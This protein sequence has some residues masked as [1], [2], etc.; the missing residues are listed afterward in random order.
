M[1]TPFN[2]GKVTSDGPY[3]LAIEEKPD[4]RIEILAGIYVLKPAV[5][6]LIPPDQYFGIDSLIKAMLASA[7]RWGATR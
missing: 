5:L 3:I 4:L 1:V 7:G 6:D 2:F